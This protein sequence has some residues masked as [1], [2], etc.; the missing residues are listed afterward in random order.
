MSAQPGYGNPQRISI[1]TYL[2]KAFLPAFKRSNSKHLL[3]KQ[4]V[5]AKEWPEY[6]E[7]KRQPGVRRLRRIERAETY[8][9]AA[10][11]QHYIETAA[12]NAYIT[13]EAMVAE[14]DSPRLRLPSK[15]LVLYDYADIEFLS[16][17]DNEEH[18]V[19]IMRDY[20]LGTVS[21]SL[22]IIAGFALD[23]PDAAA[24]QFRKSSHLCLAHHA[25]WD[26][27]A[28]HGTMLNPFP[29]LV[30]FVQPWEFGNKDFEEFTA[31]QHFQGE[32]DQPTT[33]ANKLWAVIDDTCRNR[34]RFFVVTNYTRWA[35]GELSP[36]G[37]V[38][39]ITEAF[40]ARILEFD[41]VYQ[42]TPDLGCNVVEMLTFWTAWALSRQ[43]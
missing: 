16:R 32:L 8:K 21:E 33:A 9:F 41:G 17:I 29:L 22:R 31:V 14:E 24:L 26:I 28:I 11:V 20:V 10:L 25:R 3:S 42:A 1:Q 18:C 4:I 27:L 15:N 34:G 5:R 13:N 7:L 35:F 23:S 36:R 19:T 38:V 40:E 43:A 39:S 37:D 12:A 6:A 30:F 2:S